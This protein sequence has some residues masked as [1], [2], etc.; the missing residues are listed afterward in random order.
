MVAGSFTHG[1]SSGSTTR[2]GE[3]AGV[4]GPEYFVSNLRPGLGVDQKFGDPLESMEL[5]TT[6][7]I[8]NVGGLR[9]HY[10]GCHGAYYIEDFFRTITTKELLVKISQQLTPFTPEDHIITVAAPDIWWDLDLVFLAECLLVCVD[11]LHLNHL[12][13]KIRQVHLLRWFH[14]IWVIRPNIV[15]HCMLTSLPPLQ[16]V[17]EQLLDNHHLFGTYGGDLTCIEN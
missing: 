1:G 8:C 16:G 13:R 4:E 12:E 14:R 3:G 7:G 6:D 2:T 15:S 10:T 5:S 9:V 17:F 11:K